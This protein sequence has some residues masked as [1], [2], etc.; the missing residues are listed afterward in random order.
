M[1]DV[2][3]TFERQAQWQRRRAD[4]TW[5]E[6]IR[7]AEVMREAILQLRAKSPASARK[8][9]NPESSPGKASSLISQ[10]RS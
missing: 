4:L 10:R 8:L 2:Q 1:S 7:Q 3:N 9:P 6:K 5:P